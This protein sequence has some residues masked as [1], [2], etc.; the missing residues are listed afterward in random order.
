MITAREYKKQLG[1]INAQI[2]MNKQTLRDNGHATHSPQNLLVDIMGIQ[3]AY[4]TL[5]DR[6]RR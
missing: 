6:L 4:E 5:E 1:Y 3:R 2:E